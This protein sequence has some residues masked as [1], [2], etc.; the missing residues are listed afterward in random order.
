MKKSFICAA[1]ACF[2]LTCTTS[3]TKNDV[4]TPGEI[5][6]GGSD[7]ENQTIAYFAGSTKNSDGIASRTWV[8]T[9][10]KTGSLT[11]SDY[12]GKT[13]TMNSNL[14]FTSDIS[15]FGDAGSW[16]VDGN[17]LVIHGQSMSFLFGYIK[18][19]SDRV[20]LQEISG[21]SEDESLLLEFTTT[22]Y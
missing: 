9:K 16:S 2:C 13:V 18:L 12:I 11:I 22:L 6:G 17:M 4:P 15:E 3:C 10:A 1:L 20:Q 14:E 8:C 7:S 5:N 21:K 19:A